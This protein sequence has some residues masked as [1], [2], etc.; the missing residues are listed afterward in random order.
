MT[1]QLG[2]ERAEPSVSLRARRSIARSLGHGLAFDRI[3]AVYVWIALI[4]VFSIWAP[5]TFPTVSTVKQVVNTYAITGIAA[6]AITIP[7][8]ARVFDLSFAYVINLCGVAVA[9]FVVHGVGLV[10]AVVLALLVGLGMG[11]VNGFVI[12]VMKID[13]FIGTLAT[14]ALIQ[15][16]V[17]LIT[18]DTPVNDVRLTQD[19]AKIAQTSLDG[20][21]LPV[22]Y[23]LAVALFVWYLLERTATGRRLYATGFNTDAARLAGVRVARLRFGSLLVSG[24]FSGATGIVLASTVGSGSPEVGTPY[25]LPVFAGAFLGATQLRGGRFNAGGTVIA[26]MLLGTGVTGLSL[27]GAHAWAQTMFVGVVLIAS[28]AVTGVQRRGAAGARARLLRRM[29]GRDEP[30]GAASTA[31]PVVDT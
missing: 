13:S 26:V 29:L 23:L 30:A 4:V 5:H 15:A 2:Q 21:T 24:L 14:G 22:I 9:Y 18:N 20:W 1:G 7:L 3:G 11:V 12:V 6:L 19:F 25:L 28:L 8:S 10:G 17:L 27:V 16:L 31:G